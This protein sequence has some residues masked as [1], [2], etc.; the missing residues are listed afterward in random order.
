MLSVAFNQRRRIKLH[1]KGIFN[2]EELY[3]YL[4]DFIDVNNQLKSINLIRTDLSKF[5]TSAI[6]KN[7]ILFEPARL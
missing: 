1:H 2:E 4:L 6:S 7:A 5:A 3:Q